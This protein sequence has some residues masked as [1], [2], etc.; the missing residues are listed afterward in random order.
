MPDREVEPIGDLI[1]Y[2]YAALRGRIEQ[3]SRRSG[4]YITRA[5]IE[6]HREHIVPRSLRIK[7]EC[8]RCDFVRF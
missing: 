3:S 5:E 4:A 7:A 8:E 6:L 2:Q 1:Y